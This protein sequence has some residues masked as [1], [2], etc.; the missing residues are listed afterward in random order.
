[1]ERQALR[2]PSNLVAYAKVL[3]PD[4]ERSEG[5]KLIEDEKFNKSDFKNSFLIF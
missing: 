5:Y 4:S 2:N 1:V 3:I